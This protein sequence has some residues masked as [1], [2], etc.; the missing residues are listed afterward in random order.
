MVGTYGLPDSVGRGMWDERGGQRELNLLFFSEGLLSNSEQVCA[1]SGWHLSRKTQTERVISLISIIEGE[2]NSILASELVPLASL[3]YLIRPIQHDG[4]NL[5]FPTIPSSLCASLRIERST[6]SLNE[7]SRLTL[8]AF[9][10]SSM[11][12]RSP[13]SG[14]LPSSL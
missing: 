6:T 5:H 1:K 10:V 9:F 13:S 14:T 8:M 3:N 12:R 7:T 2:Y 4:R 11:M